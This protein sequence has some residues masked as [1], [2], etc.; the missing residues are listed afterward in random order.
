MTNKYKSHKNKYYYFLYHLTLVTTSFV[1]FSLYTVNNFQ[2]EK[3]PGWLN[4]LS[5]WIT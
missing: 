5:S 3:G 1:D 4:E 2:L